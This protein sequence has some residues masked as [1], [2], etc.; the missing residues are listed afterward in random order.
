MWNMDGEEKADKGHLRSNISQRNEKDMQRISA[1]ITECCFNPGFPIIRLGFHE[2]EFEAIPHF[3][4][5]SSTKRLGID[6]LAKFELAQLSSSPLVE[7]EG[8]IPME[9][10]QK[11]FVLLSFHLFQLRESF[12]GLVFQASIT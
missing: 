3:L 10:V 9:D 4:T 7:S 1:G 8:R 2:V 5:L 11:D 12:S 6:I